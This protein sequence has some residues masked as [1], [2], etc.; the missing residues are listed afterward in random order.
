MHQP[1][2]ERTFI[3]YT[4]R[5]IVFSF[6]IFFNSLFEAP[7]IFASIFVKLLSLSMRQIKSPVANIF[8]FVN[9]ILNHSKSMH[10]PIFKFS[11]FIGAIRVNKNSIFPTDFS[12]FH[13][14]L[15]VAAVFKKVF[16]FPMKY[17][18]FPFAEIMGLSGWNVVCGKQVSSFSL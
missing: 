3:Y 13:C 11:S 17:L 15:V 1:I 9:Y 7:D 18:I 12:K 5:P 10:S 2:F 14:P 4:V 6:F 8:M 16:P